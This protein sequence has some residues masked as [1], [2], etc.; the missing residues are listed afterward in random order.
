MRRIGLALACLACVALGA[1]PEARAEDPRQAAQ[2]QF[3]EGQRAFAAGDFRRAAAA[4]EEA[5]RTKPHHS[6]LW[7]AARSWQKA[8]EGTRAANLYA[9]Y[10]EEAPAGA[11]D[12]DQAT[13]ALADLASKLGRLVVQAGGAADVRVDSAPLEGDGVY[14]P[15]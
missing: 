4:F 12:R 13:A 10:L 3:A 5:Y 2:A 9:R 6:P 8:G 14:V 15:P 1:A 11:R 7:N